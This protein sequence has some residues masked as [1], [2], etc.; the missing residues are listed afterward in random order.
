VAL[1]KDV[2]KAKGKKKTLGSEEESADD[3]GNNSSREE[4]DEALSSDEDL[5]ELRAQ[6]EQEVSLFVVVSIAATK[7]SAPTCDPS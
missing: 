7:S 1:L 4:D 2:S 6:L 5:E 3:E